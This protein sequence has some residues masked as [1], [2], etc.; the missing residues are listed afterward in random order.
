M[1]RT[2]QKRSKEVERLRRLARHRPEWAFR[3]N[4]P[5]FCSICQV[6]IATALDIHMTNTHLELG[7]FELV[8]G[9]MVR[10]LEGLRQGLSRTFA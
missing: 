10:C 1:F 6:E 9:R 5:G 7:Q 4:A 2:M 8:P 3:H